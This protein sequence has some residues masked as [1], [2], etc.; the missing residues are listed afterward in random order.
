MKQIAD[1]I[2]SILQCALDFRS[3]AALY[4]GLPDV[5]QVL[6]IKQTFDQNIKQLYTCYLNSPKNVEFSLPRFWEYLDYNH[7]YSNVINE[8]MGHRIFSI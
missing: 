7:H 4:G 5:S 3:V 2:Q 1:I 6:T 8:E